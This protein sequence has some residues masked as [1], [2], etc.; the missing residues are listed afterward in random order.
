MSTSETPK[1]EAPSQTQTPTIPPEGSPC[2]VEIMSTDPPKLKSFYESLFPSWSFK[3]LVAGDA[4]GND[5]VHYEFAKP[6][7]LSGGIVKLP[8]G[9]TPGEQPMGK[10]MTVY[11]FV[12]SIEEVCAN[13][14]STLI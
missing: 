2:W 10:G 14:P 5:V 8:E 12:V 3:N 13:S 1:S 6:A 7:G 11:Y 4:R 9:C